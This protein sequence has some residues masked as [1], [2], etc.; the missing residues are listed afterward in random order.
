VNDLV[1]KK[2]IFLLKG[3]LPN[4]IFLTGGYFNY[5]ILIVDITDRDP[6]GPADD[7]SIT[8][9]GTEAVN[10]KRAV[11]ARFSFPFPQNCALG[12]VKFFEGVS[13]DSRLKRK[14]GK[15]GTA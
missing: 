1:H 13:D 15:L 9:Y 12:A 7:R 8:V 6:M 11:S 10:Q 2:E 14:Y 3:A 4:K 5:F